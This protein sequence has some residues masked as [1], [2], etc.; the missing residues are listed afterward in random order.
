MRIVGIRKTLIL[1]YSDNM[2]PK[3]AN[4]QMKSKI[5]KSNWFRP[6]GYLDIT[7]GVNIYIFSQMKSL[8]YGA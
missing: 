3:P 7:L 4:I 6:L 8:I 2:L 5:L 1:I